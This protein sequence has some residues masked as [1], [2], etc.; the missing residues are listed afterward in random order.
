M[1]DQTSLCVHMRPTCELLNETQPPWLLQ[2]CSMHLC[3]G[4]KPLPTHFAIFYFTFRLVVH[5]PKFVIFHAFIVCS[6]YFTHLTCQ[7]VQ[8]ILVLKCSHCWFVVCTFISNFHTP[9]ANALDVK[10]LVNDV[11]AVIDEGFTHSSVNTLHLFLVF[12]LLMRCV[13]TS[14]WGRPGK[15]RQTHMGCG[16]HKHLFHKYYRSKWNV[17]N[18]TGLLKLQYKWQILND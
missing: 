15:E 2:E 7:W 9:V 17:K 1:E 14:H 3:G 10:V 11:C 8:I 13:P 5:L 18:G 4:G 16:K 12:L 6:W